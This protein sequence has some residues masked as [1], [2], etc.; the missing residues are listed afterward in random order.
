MAHR[1]SRSATNGAKI[2]NIKVLGSTL[3]RKTAFSILALFQFSLKTDPRMYRFT[4][5]FTLRPNRQQHVCSQNFHYYII[6]LSK[7]LWGFCNILLKVGDSF[8]VNP[9]QGKLSLISYM[10]AVSA[11]NWIMIDKKYESSDKSEKLGVRLTSGLEGCQWTIFSTQMLFS[12]ISFFAIPWSHT[13]WAF[14]ILPLIKEITVTC[15]WGTQTRTHTFSKWMW[16]CPFHFC[17]F[18]QKTK[19]KTRLCRKHLLW[20]IPETCAPWDV[21]KEWHGVVGHFIINL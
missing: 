18:F 3:Y 8:K 11:M 13:G 12:T 9:F 7:T 16:C 14:I 19:T 20:M 4:L 15:I 2:L 5:E 10:A 17:Q 1:S 21:K 6:L